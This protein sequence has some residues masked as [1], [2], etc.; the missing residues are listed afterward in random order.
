[1]AHSNMSA[2]K[3]PTEIRPR[4]TYQQDVFAVLGEL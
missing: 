3:K 1:M 2:G 4:L